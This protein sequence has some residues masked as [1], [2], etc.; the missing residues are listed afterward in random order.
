MGPKD[1]GDSKWLRNCG[2][3]G[4]S[5]VG[6]N[7][8]GYI[9][10]SLSGSREWGGFKMGTQLWHSRSPLCAEDPKWLNNHGGV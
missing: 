7:Q 1:G 4:L 3:L 2:L 6:S 9:A 8:N 5:S 10:A